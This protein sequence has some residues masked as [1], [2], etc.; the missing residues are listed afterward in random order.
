MARDTIYDRDLDRVPAN[1]Q[2]LT[3]LLY[4]DRAARVFP[5][6]VAVV[7]GP[8]RR[9]YREVYARAR[10]L[11]AALAARGI[12]RGDTVAALLANTPEMIECHYGVPMTGAVLNTLNTRLDAD[13]IRFCLQHGEAAVLITD[14]EFSRTAAAA[15]EGLATKPFVI[16][17]DDPEYDGPGA[18]LGATD[19]EA[20]LA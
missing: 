10:R 19:Y 14:R 8:L 13:A 3:P 15:L 2:P 1:H 18:R 4:L 5:D 6:H 12:G 16:D 17:V 11:A 9:S 7:H 20:F